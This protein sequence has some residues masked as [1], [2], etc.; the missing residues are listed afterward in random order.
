MTK[1]TESDINKLKDAGFQ[2]Y[3]ISHLKAGRFHRVSKKRFQQYKK[4]VV[5]KKSRTY[6][7]PIIIEKDRI[8]LK[9][10]VKLKP[11]G[12]INGKKKK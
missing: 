9:P 12:G 2:S 11:V 8:K 6:N 7:K 1:L 3:E 4:L 5:P 10:F